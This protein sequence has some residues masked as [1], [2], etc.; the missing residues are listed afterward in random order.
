MVTIYDIDRK[1]GHLPYM[2]IDRAE[3]LNSFFKKYNIKNCLELGFYHGKSSA[4][5]ATILNQQQEGHLT[6]IDLRSAKEMKPNINQ[7]LNELNLSQ[8]VTPYFEPKSYIWRL[9]KMIE[10]NPEPIFDFC[11]L[12][13]GHT[14]SD[15]GFGFFLVDKLLKKGGWIIF[16]DLNYC[17]KDIMKPNKENPS[18]LLKMSNEELE[19]MQVRK[20]WELLVKKHPNYTNFKEDKQWGFAQKNKK[21]AGTQI[22]ANIFRETLRKK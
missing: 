13:G 14:W 19:T 5:I 20:V 17:Y 2:N 15:T 11:Y 4:Y 3:L 12:D 21:M 16:D 10:K 6:T 22:L 18:W 9:M 8:W 1:F 7:I